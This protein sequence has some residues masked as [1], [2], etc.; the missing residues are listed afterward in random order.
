MRVSNHIIP[1]PNSVAVE[2]GVAGHVEH[3]SASRKLQGHC[4]SHGFRPSFDG[5]RVATAPPVS[6]RMETILVVQH[7]G[8]I[9]VGFLFDRNK[10]AYNNP[11]TTIAGTGCTART[12][13]KR[14]DVS[15]TN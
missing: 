8:A 7:V 5:F 15:R 12:I 14:Q 11:R 13:N 10:S 6:N 4:F 1:L 9:L 3:L 2:Q